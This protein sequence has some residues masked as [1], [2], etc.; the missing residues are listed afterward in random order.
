MQELKQST[1]PYNVEHKD[2]L[3]TIRTDQAMKVVSVFWDEESSSLLIAVQ[4]EFGNGTYQ[5]DYLHLDKKLGLTAVCTESEGVLPAFLTAPDKTVWVRLTST[6]TDKIREI[7]LPL[8]NRERIR[9]AKLLTEFVDK[10]DVRLGQE[11]IY[12]SNDIFDR[13]KKDKIGRYLFDKNHLFKNRKTYS[14]PLPSHVKALSG[15]D[16][17]QMVNVLYPDPDIILHRELQGDGVVNRQRE[18][19]LGVDVHHLYPVQLSFD[20]N[21]LFFATAGNVMLEI[22]V[23]EQGHVVHTDRLIQLDEVAEMFYNVWEPVLLKDA[24]VVR[25]NHQDGNGYIVVK[26][27]RAMECWLQKHEESVYKDNLSN[28]VVEL[29]SDSLMLT[30]LQKIA[31]DK[32]AL[33]YSRVSVES[34]DEVFKVGILHVPPGGILR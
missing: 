17:L 33:I 19:S 3:T 26:Q 23:D 1:T 28:R 4:V 18:Y 14:L 32:C 31:D 34:L 6:Q 8:A 25:F 12:F 24:Y 11:T 21:S 16:K 20:G 7:V 5:I 22:T 10:Y 30:H 15:D 2:D 9:E 27:G 13:N 29:E